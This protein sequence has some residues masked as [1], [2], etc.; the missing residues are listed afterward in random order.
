MPDRFKGSCFEYLFND[1]VLADGTDPSAIAQ[2][3]EWC[4]NNA[5]SSVVRCI[6]SLAR[7]AI[8]AFDTKPE[9]FSE[10]CPD[11]GS[12]AECVRRVLDA[13]AVWAG[14]SLQEYDEVCRSFKPADRADDGGCTLYRPA[15]IEIL[16]RSAAIRPDTAKKP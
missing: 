5:G 11:D 4:D 6:T 3:A 14:P 8:V 7:F 13:W 15:V 10:Y 16:E 2:E 1:A 9:V 12:R